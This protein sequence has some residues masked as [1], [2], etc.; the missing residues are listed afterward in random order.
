MYV[1]MYTYRHVHECT[2]I[3]T[4]I[5]MYMNVRTYVDVCTYMNYYYGLTLFIAEKKFEADRSRRVNL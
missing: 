4:R 2:Y 1:H 3:C 5:D